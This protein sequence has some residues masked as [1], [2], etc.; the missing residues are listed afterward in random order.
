M[1]KSATITFNRFMLNKCFDQ[2][3]IGNPDNTINKYLNSIDPPPPL[4]ANYTMDYI[5]MGNNGYE[6]INGPKNPSDLPIQGVPGRNN[7]IGV[8]YKFLPFRVMKEG[9]DLTDQERSI[10]G[11]R[12]RIIMDGEYHIAYFAKRVAVEETED[13]ITTNATGESVT[14]P[15]EPVMHP[16][17]AT[18]ITG[19]DNVTISKKINIE[20]TAPDIAAA[21]KYARGVL[22]GEEHG[23]I[24]EIGVCIGAEGSDPLPTFSGLELVSSANV[25]WIAGIKEP[26]TIQL[27]FGR[28][29][30]VIRL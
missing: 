22:G 6:T 3:F 30:S 4:G 17:R 27:S 10:F 15:I 24:R 19:T 13:I 26:R 14:Q 9:S 28:A 2:V 8:L 5:V 29:T 25:G 21:R 18:E 23:I 16:I 1:N 7:R 20:I 11:V 12:K